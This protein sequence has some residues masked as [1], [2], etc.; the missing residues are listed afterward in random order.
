M[1]LIVQTITAIVVLC[2]VREDARLVGKLR[3]KSR[4]SNPHDGMHF[5]QCHRLMEGSAPKTFPPSRY[6]AKQQQC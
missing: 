3:T 2:L 5:D 6:L 1:V 4:R